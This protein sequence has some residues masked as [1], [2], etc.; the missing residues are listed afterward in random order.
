MPPSARGRSDDSAPQFAALKVTWERG[1]WAAGAARPVVE[2][3]NSFDNRNLNKHGCVMKLQVPFIQLPL[4][5][6]TARLASE[7]QA[8]GSAA[9][10]PHPQKYPGNFALPLIAA[11]GDPDS[12]AIAGPMRPTPYLD[13]CTYLRQVLARLGAVWGR[14]RLMKLTA[15]AEVTTHADINYYWRERTR[16]HVPIQTSPGVRFIC[17]EAEINMAAG[18]CWIFDTWRPH[19]VINA[20][21]TER[22]HLVAD[23][24]GSPEFWDLVARG[25]LPGAS[26][27]NTS[28]WK[29]ELFPAGNSS[30]PTDLVLESINVPA[31]MTPWEL[32]EHIRFIFE[33]SEP[34]AQ[35]AEVQQQTG[36]FVAGWQALWARY[37]VARE[38]WSAYRGALDHY[39]RRMENLAA[40]LRLSNGMRFLPTLRSMVLNV[41][42][43]D[44]NDSPAADEPRV[45]GVAGGRQGP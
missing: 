13:S 36:R 27:V 19:H 35:L 30:A 42:L 1:S 44:R 8:L 31:V 22:I 9:W 40:T 34:H 12:D 2:S 18:E 25:R 14:T 28:G 26:G 38:G 5:F 29:A 45:P 21:P 4:Q 23:T 32:R 11:H 15:G 6:D 3:G 7:I 20:A 17:G 37:G 43:A 16:V 33:H 24:V 41:A 10:R 39:T